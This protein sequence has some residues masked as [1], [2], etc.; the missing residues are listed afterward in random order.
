[1]VHTS[2][3]AVN[4]DTNLGPIQRIEGWV[5]YGGTKGG[6]EARIRLYMALKV[7]LR[8][9]GTKSKVKDSLPGACILKYLPM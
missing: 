1:M 4:R 8:K 5:G 3:A 9:V 6:D 7:R 2:R